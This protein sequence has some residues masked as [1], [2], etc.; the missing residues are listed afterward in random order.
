MGESVS[1]CSISWTAWEMSGT[2]NSCGS[3]GDIVS[4]PWSVRWTEWPRSSST[5]YSSSS[6]ARIFCSRAGSLRSARRSSSTR[7]TSCLTPVS[8]SS[9]SSFLFLGMPSCALYSSRA[10][11]YCVFSSC[12][13]GSALAMRSFATAVCLRTSWTTWA[14]NWAYFSSDS[15]PT[16]PEMMRGVRA[17]SMRIESTSSMIA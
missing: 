4:T 7:C 15:A 9:F 16:G 14:L 11:S 3:C 10:P 2:T 13:S 6:R 12:S 5:K 1:S 8:L 17:S